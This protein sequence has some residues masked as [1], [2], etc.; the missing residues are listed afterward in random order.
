MQAYM[1]GVGGR[2]HNATIRRWRAALPTWALSQIQGTRA[3]AKPLTDTIPS[4][5]RTR[6]IKAHLLHMS[7]SDR[8]KESP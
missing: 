6:F 8:Y 7:C 5:I 3:R 2:H 1:R 4:T